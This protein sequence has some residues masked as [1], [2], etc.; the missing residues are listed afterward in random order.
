MYFLNYLFSPHPLLEGGGEG[1]ELPHASQWEGSYRW[2]VA[3]HA[4]HPFQSLKTATPRHLRGALK[5]HYLMLSQEM[6]SPINLWGF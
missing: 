1:R 3:P 5:V 2:L 4:A 6:T